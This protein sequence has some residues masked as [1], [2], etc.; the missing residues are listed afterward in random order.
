MARKCIACGA[1]N[2]DEISACGS[3]GEPLT[4]SKEEFGL[5]VPT[6]RADSRGTQIS[7]LGRREPR[8]EII[9]LSIL[10][11][12][13]GFVFL[14]YSIIDVQEHDTYT[15]TEG[16]MDMFHAALLVFSLFV[17]VAVALLL[18]RSELLQEGK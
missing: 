13:I 3:C 4:D 12:V 5:R 9:W 17:V 6:G 14:V 16:A 7:E 11:M 10:G 8:T 18:A 1:L 2:S 15:A